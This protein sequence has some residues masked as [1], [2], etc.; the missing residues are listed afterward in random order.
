MY[1]PH[2]V[3]LPF[4]LVRWWLKAVPLLVPIGSFT[5][6]VASVRHVMNWMK[7]SF[8]KWFKSN[9][10]NSFPG[11][12]ARRFFKLDCKISKVK[13]LPWTFAKT[14]PND[15]FL[16]F[17]HGC[18]SVIR[19]CGKFGPSYTKQSAEKNGGK[20]GARSRDGHAEHVCKTTRSITLETGVDIYTS[21]RITC[22]FYVWRVVAWN[23]LL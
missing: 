6:K 7:T 17:L 4:P 2:L 23:Y 22:V 21:V 16:F 1:R 5:C 14:W 18:W 13:R 9:D 3:S 20:K 11:Q 8:F 19:I 12:I 15:F 10:G